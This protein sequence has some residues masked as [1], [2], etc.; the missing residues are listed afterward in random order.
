[1]VYDVIKTYWRLKFFK[2]YWS[3]KFFSNGFKINLSLQQKWNYFFESL[4]ICHETLFHWKM[5][6]IVS[7]RE[8][9]LDS[10]A[11]AKIGSVLT[12]H[13]HEK[14]SFAA[15]IPTNQL[16]IHL[17]ERSGHSLRPLALIYPQWGDACIHKEYPQPRVTHIVSFTYTYSVIN[18]WWISGSL[19]IENKRKLFYESRP[20]W[21]EYPWREN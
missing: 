19:F 17:I 10:E 11:F 21:L 9:L 4:S 5:F 12:L 7:V 20:C 2:I 8:V 3:L 16:M 18:Y 1:M 13:L 15:V 6:K 14:F